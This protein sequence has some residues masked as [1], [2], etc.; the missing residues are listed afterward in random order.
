MLQNT[1]ACSDLSLIH[2]STIERSLKIY[3]PDLFWTFTPFCMSNYNFIAILGQHIHHFN[4]FPFLFPFWHL[5]NGLWL[6]SADFFFI[7]NYTIK[8]PGTRNSWFLFIMPSWKWTL[9]LCVFCNVQIKCLRS[10]L[11]QKYS[12]LVRSDSV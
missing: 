1:C 9:Q 2:M 5:P 7:K 11:V 10:G 3:Q 4:I 8:K 12:P 6:S